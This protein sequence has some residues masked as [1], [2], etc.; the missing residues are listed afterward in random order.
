MP[1]NA[2]LIEAIAAAAEVAGVDV[3]ETEGKKNNE[4]SATLAELKALPAAD[5]EAEAKAAAEAEAK[6]AAE[7][8]A[9]A[10]YAVAKAP[11]AVA[12]GKAVTSRRGILSDGAAVAARDLAGGDAALKALVK[13]GHVVK[14]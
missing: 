6:A 12:K 2:E 1:S 5:A 3:P 4:L 7:A 8:E 9:K 14:N 10:P 11:Y 13:S